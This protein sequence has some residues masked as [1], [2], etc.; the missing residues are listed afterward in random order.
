[1]TRLETPTIDPGDELVCLGHGEDLPAQGGSVMP[2]IV[3]ASLFTR[4]TLDELIDAL[5]AEH[6]N[7]LYSRGQNPTVEAVEKKL[8]TLERGEACKCTASGMAAVSATL[9]GLLEA[10]DHVLFVNNVYGPTLQLAQ[11]LTRFGVRDVT[12]G[13]TELCC[14]DHARHDGSKV[15]DGENAQ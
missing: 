9:M 5:G 6:K 3:Q 2:P 15:C 14:V 11:R 12:L 1:M 13:D 7:H 4:P 10:G 8:A